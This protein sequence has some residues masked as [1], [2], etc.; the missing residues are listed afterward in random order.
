MVQINTLVF[1]AKRTVL[2]TRCLASQSREFLYGRAAYAIVARPNCTAQK[3]FELYEYEEAR[4]PGHGPLLT[5]A[6]PAQA[7]GFDRKK[8]PRGF[9]A[10]R[11]MLDVASSV[12]QRTSHAES[13]CCNARAKWRTCTTSQCPARQVTDGAA[14]AG[15]GVACR[16]VRRRPTT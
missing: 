6:Q 15:A 1:T 14:L 13:M 10:I 12:G 3:G 16:C 11:C 7:L 5:D 8:S 4:P 2:G 9:P